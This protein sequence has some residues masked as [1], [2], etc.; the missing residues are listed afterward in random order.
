MIQE[1]ENIEFIVEKPEPKSSKKGVMRELID[2]S[3]L[4]REAVV[5][6]LPFVLFLTLLAFFYIGNRYHAERLVRKSNDLHR[7]LRDYRAQAITISAEL[8][9]ISR[10]SEVL[11]LVRQ[12]EL[13]LVESTEPPK[14]LVIKR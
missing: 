5:R 8:M 11:K 6:Q 1:K 10:Q 14:K 2:G 9:H 3:V 7:E 12:K 13:G 4:N